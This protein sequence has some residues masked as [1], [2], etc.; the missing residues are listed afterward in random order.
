MENYTELARQLLKI[1]SEA[2]TKKIYGS[3]E[4]YFE[5]GKVTQITHRII[6]KIHKKG[7]YTKDKV[8]EVRG[9]G[10]GKDRQEAEGRNTLL[11]S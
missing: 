9:N 4:V 10:D 3:I 6:N 5:A 8:K 7:H 1:V 11:T 2:V